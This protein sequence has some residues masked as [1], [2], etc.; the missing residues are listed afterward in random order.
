MTPQNKIA[1]YAWALYDLA[2]TIFSM[3]ILSLYFA[4]WVTVE[5]GAK[6]IH[7]SLVYSGSMFVSLILAPVLGRLA[8]FYNKRL[9]GLIV[10]TLVCVAAT[11]CIGIFNRLT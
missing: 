11:A 9:F 4:L 7:Y 1:P 8:D 5:M 3:N 6:D 2:N 10:S